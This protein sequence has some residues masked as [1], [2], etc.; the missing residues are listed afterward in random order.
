MTAIKMT[1]IKLAWPN[2]RHCME[3]VFS[4][5][6]PSEANIQEAAQAGIRTVV[7]LCGEGEAGWDEESA[8]EDAGMRY[9][10]IPVC[11]PQDVCEPRAK[12]LDVVLNDAGLRPMVIHCGSGNRVGA[13]VALREFHCVGDDAE[14][15]VSKGRE[16]GLL[17]LEP[18]VRK[19]LNC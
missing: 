16:A 7:D 13:L 5:G 15:A 1:D 4:A 3:G 2:A 14:T 8:V 9:V 18:H 12:E 17:G 19:C 6:M 10:H 11:G